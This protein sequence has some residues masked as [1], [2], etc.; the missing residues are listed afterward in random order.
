MIASCITPTTDTEVQDRALFRLMA[1]SDV[2]ANLLPYD[3]FTDQADQPYGLSRLATL[4]KRLRTETANTLLVDN[5]DM[6]QGTPLS[7]FSRT[8]A[9]DTAPDTP[10]EDTLNPIIDAMNALG[11]DAA[12][13]GNHEFNFGL[14]WLQRATG[15]ARFPYVASNLTPAREE[16]RFWASQ[17]L[18]HRDVTCASGAT[19]PLTIGLLSLVPPQILT[20]DR[21]HLDGH[22][23]CTDMTDIAERLVPAL[24]AEG[25]D[26]V[27]V[28]AHTGFGP[29]ASL[30]GL[31]NAALPLSRIPGIDGLVTGHIHD[32]FP[33]G[34]A[35]AAPGTEIDE[36]RGRINGTA[37]VMPGFRGSHLGVIEFDLLRRDDRWRLCAATARALPVA[38]HHAETLPPDPA[39]D[40]RLTPAHHATLAQTR[41]SIGTTSAP[42]HSYLSLLGHNPAERLVAGAQRR[43]LAHAVE[44]GPLADLPIL[45][46]VA[47]FKTGGRGGPDYF[48]DIPAGPL[49]LRHG[50][51]LYAFPN[52]LIG[53]VVTGR[54]LRHWL[55]CAA[56]V[57][58]QVAP[59]ARDAKLCNLEA[60]GHIFEVIDGLTY[61]IDL[62]QPPRFSLTGEEIA[63]GTSRIHALC[64][65]GKP[66]QEDDRFLLAT[67]HYR[68]AGSGPF[69]AI[70]PDR[71]IMPSRALLRDLIIADLAETGQIT[72]PEDPV[73]RFRP[74]PGTTVVC[75]SG[76]GLRHVPL[77]PRF[78]GIEFL[79]LDDDGFQKFRLAL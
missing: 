76:P 20:W 78:A 38:P 16:D 36:S 46:S 29:E 21:H 13:L 32:V 70:A 25:A 47:P 43:A 71:W 35:L 23:T 55:D 79:D 59:G 54:E 6:L 24:R 74:M 73:W 14:A 68:A 41:R 40:A 50:A 57:Y 64:Y 60:P 53:A 65:Q 9:P 10:S 30:P 67:N 61:E 66:V 48:T 7:D 72:P 28:L 27:I 2:H 15:Q 56:L 4:I 8:P 33:G 62:A 52:T 58:L 63:P 18:L 69:P 49:A 51:D 17:L 31:E 77:P 75:R 34:K 11:Y 42:L 26:L 12:G 45:S 37:T 1:T 44:G 5:G 19:Y 39:L 22:I 3:Y